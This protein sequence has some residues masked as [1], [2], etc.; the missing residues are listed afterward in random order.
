M[1]TEWAVREASVERLPS[2]NDR[3]RVHLFGVFF[4]ALDGRVITVL[5]VGPPRPLL[6]PT[7]VVQLLISVP[8]VCYYLPGREVLSDQ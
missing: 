7:R 6:A 3:S 1:A 8:L 2:V 5:R 4:F